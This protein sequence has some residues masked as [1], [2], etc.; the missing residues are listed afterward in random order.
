VV[1][2]ADRKQLPPLPRLDRITESD[3]SLQPSATPSAQSSPSPKPKVSKSAK[4][5]EDGNSSGDEDKGGHNKGKGRGKPLMARKAH[6]RHIRLCEL[7]DRLRI[8]WRWAAARHSSPGRA[9][10][11]GS[12]HSEQC[13]Q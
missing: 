13:L 7:R 12:R 10:A 8:T 2:P 11:S 3:R 9:L 5:D 1:F 6:L 4:P